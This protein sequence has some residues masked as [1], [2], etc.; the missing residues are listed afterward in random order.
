MLGVMLINKGFL[1]YWLGTVLDYCSDVRLDILDVT[2][3]H[4]VI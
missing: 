2:E 4:V 3:E 1:N